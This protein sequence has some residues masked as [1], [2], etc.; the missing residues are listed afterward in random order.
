VIT[1]PLSLINLA[2]FLLLAKK[3]RTGWLLTILGE[4]LWGAYGSW[5]GQWGLAAGGFVTA[6]FQF[7]GWLK[8][9]RRTD[10]HARP[11]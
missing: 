6:V 2:G 7:R 8:W 9:R 4:S 5:T 11:A 10:E 3:Y 1:V